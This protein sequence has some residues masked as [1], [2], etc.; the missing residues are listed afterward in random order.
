MNDD[1]APPEKGPRARA[2]WRPA[3]MGRRVARRYH[4]GLIPVHVYAPET[5]TNLEAQAHHLTDQG[6]VLGVPQPLEVGCTLVIRM[7]AWQTLP[8]TVMTAQAVNTSEEDD[9]GW[10]IGCAFV[11][12]NGRQKRDTRS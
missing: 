4:C 3:R 2:G 10:R 12:P 11:L 7:Q 1:T 5:A 8:A 6:L 9:G